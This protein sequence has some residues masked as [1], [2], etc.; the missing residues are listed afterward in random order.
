MISDGILQVGGS[1]MERLAVAHLVSVYL[2][3]LTQ[4]DV[5]T[6]STPP[7]PLCHSHAG[8]FCPENTFL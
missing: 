4:P 1:V 3:K 8:T 5:F 7:P 2:R 6:K